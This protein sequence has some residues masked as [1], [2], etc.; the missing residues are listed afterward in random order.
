MSDKHF[1]IFMAALVLIGAPLMIF[2]I[3]SMTEN[4][5]PKPYSPI[6]HAQKLC[7]NHGGI[8][9]MKAKQMSWSY[10]RGVEVKC[11]DGARLQG[12]HGDE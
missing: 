10:P 6:S 5:G 9:S 12:F 3:D 11:N 8:R 7:E 4:E 2:F 1:Y